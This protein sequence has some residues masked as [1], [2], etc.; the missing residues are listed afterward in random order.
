MH[1]QGEMCIFCKMCENIAKC[2]SIS[3]PSKVPRFPDPSFIVEDSNNIL[4]V[5]QN[6]GKK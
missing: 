6:H 3:S 2:I 5:N 4:I 1:D